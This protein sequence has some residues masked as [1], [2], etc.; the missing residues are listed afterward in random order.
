MAPASF[1]Y[2]SFVVLVGTSRPNFQ[3][4]L[5]SNTR[6]QAQDSAHERKQD[7]EERS[8]RECIH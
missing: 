7:D 3:H 6:S 4:D 5:S 1:A 2:P 8:G